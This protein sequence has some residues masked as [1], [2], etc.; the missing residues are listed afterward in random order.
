MI[1]GSMLEQATTD[2]VLYFSNGVPQL[3]HHRLPFESINYVRVCRSRHD[4]E[5]ND[6]RLRTRLLKVVV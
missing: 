3:F 2:S 1:P 5:R 6:G 4:D